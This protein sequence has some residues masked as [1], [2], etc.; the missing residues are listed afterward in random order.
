MLY[1]ARLLHCKTVLSTIMLFSLLF[2]LFLFKRQCYV[3]YLLAYYLF[4]NHSG[5]KQFCLCCIIYYP[6]LSSIFS[7]PYDSSVQFITRHYITV[8]APHAFKLNP[9]RVPVHTLTAGC[10]LAHGALLYKSHL[11][12][13]SHTFI[14]AC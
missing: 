11:C 14:P 5:P 4:G 2:M 12:S 8:S 6:P 7:T 1:R 9:Q 10:F 13:L 3:C